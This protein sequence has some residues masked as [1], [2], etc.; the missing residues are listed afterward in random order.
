MVIEHQRSTYFQGLLGGI[1]SEFFR[2]TLSK[3]VSFGKKVVLYSKWLSDKEWR[4]ITSGK[5]YPT[6]VAI[7]KITSKVL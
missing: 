5:V 3:S 2:I 1:L 7:G 4:S 6:M